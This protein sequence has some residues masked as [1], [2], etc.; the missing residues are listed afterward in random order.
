MSHLIPI[1]ASLTLVVLNLRAT[2]V[3]SVTTTALPAIQ[4][5]SKL[6]E[7]LI[8]ASIAA[9]VLTVIRAQVLGSTPFPFG[10]LTAPFRTIDISHLWSLD[11]W[12]SI[13]SRSCHS[14]RTI[15]VLLILPAAVLLAALVGPSSAV[16]MIPRPMYHNGTRLLMIMNSIPQTY[17][18][19]VD[20]VEGEF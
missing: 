3:G 2:F 14:W 12:G 10:G 6:L 9:M 19:S 8:Q 11:L 5:A 4:F 20:L 17:P 18:Q 15:V 16:L 1:A 13:T 7:T